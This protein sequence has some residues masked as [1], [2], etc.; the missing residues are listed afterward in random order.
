MFFFLSLSLFRIAVVVAIDFTQTILRNS[1]YCARNA[2]CFCLVCLF[3][4]LKCDSELFYFYFGRDACSHTDRTCVLF[5]CW[6]ATIALFFYLKIFM[7]SSNGAPP[8]AF[9][10]WMNR[11]SKIEAHHINYDLIGDGRWANIFILVSVGV[12]F[13]YF[14]S[15]N[16]DIACTLFYFRTK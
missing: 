13:F 2:I 11:D 3:Y 15:I 4:F 12:F 1:F 14:I 10:N 9:N 8:K 5:W 6:M 7:F 16:Q